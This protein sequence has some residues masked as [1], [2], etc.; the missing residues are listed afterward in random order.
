MIP[1]INFKPFM[2]GDTNAR[3]E[4]ANKMRSASET[5]GFFALTDFGVSEAEIRKA[6]AAS[7][8]FFAL[9][10]SAKAAL[11][12]E[13]AESNRGYIGLRRE[14][15]DPSQQPDLKEAF[16]TGSKLAEQDVSNPIKNKWPTDLDHFRETIEPFIDR[17]NALANRILEAL[18]LALNIQTDFFVKA[19]QQQNNIFR[20]LHYPAL[21]AEVSEGEN[22]AGA[23]TDYGSI[24]LLFQDSVGGLEVKDKGGNW[25]DIAPVPGSLVVNIGDMMQR[26][27]N[28]VLASNP[29]RVVQPP[30]SRG[31]D[32]YSMAYFCTPDP[33]QIIATLP[34]CLS[35]DNPQKYAPISSQDHLLERLNR[36]Y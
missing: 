33:E 23:H 25:L 4:V 18:A 26:W 32:R 10:V 27:S 12:W 28:D 16:N 17:C 19:H 13:K 6:F 2:V 5:V 34:T 15:L 31:R 24:T 22:R 1:L 36:T 35:D 21:N 3:R 29:H 11:A 14:T 20:L 9:P 8:D 30:Q 7:K